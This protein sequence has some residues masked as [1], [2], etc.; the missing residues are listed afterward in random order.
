[1][2]AGW[3]CLVRRLLSLLLVLLMMGLPAP[4]Q[5][6]SPKPSRP[7]HV[8]LLT[9]RNDEF[10][11]LAARITQAAGQDLG[12]EVEWL[13][14][15]NDPKKHLADAL[16]VLSRPVKP[17][18][19]LLKNFDG[20]ARPIIEAAEKAGVYTLFFE[21]GLQGEDA[22]AIG[23][24]RE[25]LKYWLGEFLPDHF[26]A[27]YDL[28]QALI[29]RARQRFPKEKLSMVAI[30]GNMIEYSSADRVRG[31]MVAL[32]EH[33]DVLLH[34]IAAAYWKAD[35]AEIK[36]SRL[37]QAYPDT[38]ILWAINDTMPVGAAKAVDSLRSQGLLSR[39][40]LIGGCGTTPPAAADIFNRRVEVSVG[41]HF[42]LPAFTLVLMYD[43][44]HGA[45]FARESTLMRLRMF[46]FDAANIKRYY[47]VFGRRPDPASWSRVDFS[48]FSKAHHPEMLKY[49]FGFQ[50]I[51][52]QL[53]K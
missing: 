37:L 33:P 51:L 38:H 42:L 40:P 53:E 4:A 1:M 50:E 47:E 21:D 27:G 14:A 28:T 48:R 7:F 20:T 19:I 46:L 32:R 24:P 15:L 17:D 36:A 13:P 2:T 31:M 43:Y 11:T 8:V 26:E 34:E 22:R 30:A 18:A 5:Q 23:R 35:A 16:S 41:G 39:Q 49:R 29:A 3:S 52:A 44:L 6:T 12:I 10:W 25:K 9:P 45:D